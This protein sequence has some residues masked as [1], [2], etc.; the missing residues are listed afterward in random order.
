MGGLGWMFQPGVGECTDVGV[1]SGE[2]GV[3]AGGGAVEIGAIVY[4]LRPLG[5]V[6]LGVR[7]CRVLGVYRKAEKVN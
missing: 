6:D 3:D 2:E 7:G 5:G 1:R 4:V